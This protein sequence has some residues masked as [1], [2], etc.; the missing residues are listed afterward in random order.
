[1]FFVVIPSR[2]DGEGRHSRTNDI[3]LTASRT[4]QFGVEQRREFFV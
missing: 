2:A 4:A 3:R 1:M